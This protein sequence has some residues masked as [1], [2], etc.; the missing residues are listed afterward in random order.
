MDKMTSRHLSWTSCLG[1][2]QKFIVK[3]AWSV[4]QRSVYAT[5]LI[6]D[7]HYL[8][9][10]W[11][12]SKCTES[13]PSQEPLRPVQRLSLYADNRFRVETSRSLA[14]SNLNVIKM[15]ILI[16]WTWTIPVLTFSIR[17]KLA[18]RLHPRSV[19]ALGTF[20]EMHINSQLTLYYCF[21]KG[22]QIFQ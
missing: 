18:L 3:M 13:A 7:A 19:S 8:K 22:M 20:I 10:I 21:C 9:N 11:A 4:D 5:V 14:I 6:I 16:S 15:Y 17:N 2:L 1:L 12:S